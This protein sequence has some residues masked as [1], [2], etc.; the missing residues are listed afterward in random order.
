MCVICILK[1]E[2]SVILHMRCFILQ[3]QCAGIGV[4]VY[5]NNI[6]SYKHTKMLFGKA[7]DL[8]ETIRDGKI[9]ILAIQRRS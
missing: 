7:G 3:T 6:V 1:D 5:C 8:L 4:P 9:K 2:K